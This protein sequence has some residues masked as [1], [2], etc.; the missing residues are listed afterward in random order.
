MNADAGDSRLRIERTL[1]ASIEAVFAA[2]TSPESMARWLSPWGHA[3][4]ECEPRVAGRLR[5]VMVEGDVRIEHTGEYV[6]F[7]PPRRLSFTLQSPYTGSGPSLVTVTLSP[8]GDGTRLELVHEQL[9]TDQV[10][11]HEGGWGTILD[12]LAVALGAETSSDEPR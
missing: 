6:E 5:V 4:V 12:R 11:P 2:W 10:T 3:E 7:D 9:P 8:D 1:P